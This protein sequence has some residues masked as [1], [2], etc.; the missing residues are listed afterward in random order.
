MVSA[1]LR[2]LVVG[3]VATILSKRPGEIFSVTDVMSVLRADLDADTLGQKRVDIFEAVVD[4]PNIEAAGFECWR[5][6]NPV[7]PLAKFAAAIHGFPKT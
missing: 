2:L 5:V 7:H 1:S 6:I 4:L 3:A